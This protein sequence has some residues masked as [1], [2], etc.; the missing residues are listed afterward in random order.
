MALLGNGTPANP[1]SVTFASGSALA[2]DTSAATGGFSYGDTIAG[3]ENVAVLGGHALTLDPG[4]AGNTYTGTTTVSAG[5]LDVDTPAALPGY[6]ASGDVSVA[7]NATL[8]VMVGGSGWNSDGLDD[9]AALLSNADF[10]GGAWLGIDTGNAGSGF[11]YAGTIVDTSGGSL[12]LDVFGGNTLELL[13][14]STYSGPTAIGQNTTLEMGA[15]DAL[16]STTVVTLG[17]GA[18]LNLNELPQDIAGLASPATGPSGCVNMDDAQL[19]LDTSVSQSYGGTLCGDAAEYGSPGSKL[20]VTGS[21]IQTLTGNNGY[22]GVAGSDYCGTIEVTSG[23]TLDAGSLYALGGARWLS[24]NYKYNNFSNVTVDDGGTLAVMVGSTTDSDW[25]A[26]DITAL[27]APATGATFADGASLGID[28]TDATSGFTL[29]DVADTSSTASLGLTVLGGNT[30]TLSGTNT[31]SGPT[32]VLAGMLDAA[33]PGA[34]PGYDLP[35]QISVASG[36]TLAVMVGGTSDWDSIACPNTIATL[37]GNADFSAGASLGLDTSDLASGS[38]AYPGQ[39]VDTPNGQLGLVVLGDKTLALN[40]A[41]TYSGPTVVN[42]G[43]TL[44]VDSTSA[45]PAST[46]VSVDGSLNLLNSACS[47]VA[48]AG[49]AGSGTV[50][51]DGQHLTI[52]ASTSQTFGGTL[53]GD[54]NSKLII[55]GSGT[56]V[57]GADNSSSFSGTINVGP[58]D[59][60]ATLEAQLPT[61][62]GSATDNFSNVTV[63]DGA[64][65]A[66]MVGGSDEW[67]SSNDD[68][69]ALVNG[70]AHADFQPGSS[71]GIDA[72]H[73]PSGGYT[74]TSIIGNPGGSLGLAVLGDNSLTLA[75][76]GGVNSYTGGTT[77]AAGATLVAGSS[78]AI[79]SGPLNV[80]GTLDLAGS[81]LTATSLN[82]NGEID[83]GAATLTVGGATSPGTFSGTIDGAAP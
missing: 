58:D 46:V 25:D 77:I 68:I 24:E 22:N 60:G 76:T 35:G 19:T 32:N 82:G 45:L 17:N 20:I 27:L 36:A 55:D 3:P 13:G 64:T 51:F 63:E 52:D 28:T 42:E 40:E 79:P 44:D 34:L 30:L 41:D 18:S 39:I 49:L 7:A 16:P 80:N 70:S 38:F 21:G 5:T 37:L 81:N 72:S 57:L 53:D 10:A 65:L 74:C 61:A 1:G 83:L 9:I 67:N 69:G 78:G 23:A 43:T 4:P 15:D 11:T 2:F 26:D 50:A 31:Y 48:I 12:G 14:A 8:A 47:N 75:P 66:V 6:D 33:S 71:L 56:Q 59:E 62:L 29:S 73:A 54:T